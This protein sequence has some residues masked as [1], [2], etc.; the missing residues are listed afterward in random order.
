MGLLSLYLNFQI[1]DFYV[2]FLLLMVPMISSCNLV[3]LFAHVEFLGEINRRI[4]MYA[5]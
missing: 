5:V 3:N 4:I 1:S 2:K